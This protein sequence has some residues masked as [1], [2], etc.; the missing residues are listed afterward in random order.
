M[1]KSKILSSEHVFIAGGTGSGKTYLCEQYL[2]G[3]DNVIVLDTKGFFNW[4]SS[5]DLIPVFETLSELMEF[6]EGKAIYRPR[7]EELNQEYYNLFLEWIYRRRNTVVV[8]DELMEVAPS[9]STYPPYL[10]GILTRGRQLNV[11]CWCLTQRPKDIPIIAMSEATHFFIF[12]L[13]FPDDR[14]RIAKIIGYDEVLEPAGDFSQYRFWYFNA[15]K[16]E[17]PV[18]GVLK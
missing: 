10:K 14:E 4:D 9:P 11:G 2:N 7:F 3:F 13:N 17:R 6:K 15:K 18:R 5:I 8:I 12:R 1:S 16:T